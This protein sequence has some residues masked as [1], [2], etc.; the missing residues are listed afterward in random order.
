MNAFAT[1]LLIILAGLAIAF[2]VGI[3]WAI[4]GGVER[5]VESDLRRYRK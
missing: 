3:V 4:L 5:I 1:V 2:A